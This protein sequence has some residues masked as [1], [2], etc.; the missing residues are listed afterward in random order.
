MEPDGDGTHA[1]LRARGDD[2]PVQASAGDA[3]SPLTV[4]RTAP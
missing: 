2:L 4:P 1:P 3:R